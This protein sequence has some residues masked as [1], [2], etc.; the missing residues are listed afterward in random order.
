MTSPIS[1]GRLAV[2]VMIIAAHSSGPVAAQKLPVA[3]PQA[4]ENHALVKRTISGAFFVTKPLKEE[5]DRLV[6]RLRLLKADIDSGRTTGA[7]ALKDW[8]DFVKGKLPAE[9]KGKAE[10]EI[11]SVQAKAREEFERLRK[12]ADGLVQENKMAEAVD[13][14]KQQ[15][16]RFE[17]PDLKDLYG[18]LETTLKK[19]DK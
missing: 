1:T 3:K 8:G 10:G 16:A 19:Y 9:T 11:R 13:L 14:I 5:Y 12:K 18:E 15:L 6:D 2:I 17:H 4:P 7:A